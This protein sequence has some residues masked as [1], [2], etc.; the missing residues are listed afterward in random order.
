M[1]NFILLYVLG[2]WIAK[3]SVLGRIR[4][5]SYFA[6]FLGSCFL[7]SVIAVLILS[8]SDQSIRQV[9]A[10]NNPL[11]VLASV[12]IVL[13][14]SKLNF[15]SKIINTIA[16]TV[17]AALFVQHIFFLSHPSI[18]TIFSPAFVFGIVTPILFV[19][20][21][22]IEYPRK[23]ITTKLISSITRFVS[24]RLKK[25]ETFNHHDQLE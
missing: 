22:L 4:R 5:W 11:V 19:I 15:K 10:Y 17:V 7:N 3:E 13:F 12:S 21:F 20:A 8:F 14:F 24:N 25:N 9:F 16:S 6:L 18:K 23:R 1:Y 2:D